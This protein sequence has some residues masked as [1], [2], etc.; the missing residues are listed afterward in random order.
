MRYAAYFGVSI[1]LLIMGVGLSFG[2]AS[3]ADSLP[4]VCRPKLAPPQTIQLGKPGI[5]SWSCEG[6]QRAGSGYYIVFIRPSG[7]YVLLKVPEGRMSFEFTPDAVGAWRWIVINT[8]PDGAKPDVE[9]E[10]GAFVVW[11]NEPSKN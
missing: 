5:F 2:W 11:Q 6:A 10:P 8:D 1:A 4:N 7:T 9:S 3:Q